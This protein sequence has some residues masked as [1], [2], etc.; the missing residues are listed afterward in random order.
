M[1]T[2][3]LVLDRR[4]FLGALATIP[5]AASIV[6]C[7]PVDD[8]DEDLLEGESSLAEG[9][10]ATSYVTLDL[11]KDC[12]AKGDGKT[13]DTSAFQEAARRIW[14]AGGGT[15]NIPAGTYIVG[16][17]KKKTNP[18]APGPFYQYEEIFTIDAREKHPTAN[19][20]IKVTKVAINGYGA[21]VRIASG[22]H[23]GGFNP[24]TGAPMDA[25]AGM[26]KEEN[27]AKIGRIFE[28]IACDG[29]SIRGLELDGNSPNLVLG[30]EW[31][32]TGRQAAA[33]GIVLE[34]CVSASV[35]DVY[36]HHHGLDGI[37]VS[38][39]GA[40]PET[41]QMHRLTR[42]ISEYNGRQAMS[43]IGGRGLRCKDCKFNHTG[44]AINKGTG[45]PL[46]SKPLA[47]VDIEPNAGT[48]EKSSEGVFISC[49]F[50]NNAGAGLLSSVGNG[51]WTTFE[52]CT[53][54]GTTSYSLWLGHPGLKFVG[55]RVYGTAM[56]VSDGRSDDD[57]KPNPALATVFEDCDF[58]DKEWK[59]GKVRRAGVL[60]EIP[61][62]KD[63]TSH[64]A[65]ATFRNCRFKANKVRGLLVKDRTSRENFIGCT[66]VHG[67][68]LGA[69]DYQSS[70][71]GSTFTSCHFKETTGVGTKNYRID[72]DN[73][74][75]RVPPAGAQPTTVD[76]PRVH[77][78]TA[79]GATGTIKPGTYTT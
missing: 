64:S 56:N 72:L 23:Y 54:W 41:T 29:V 8:E 71:E 2:K 6:G 65:G 77:W 45:Q 24:R 70:F 14:A 66:F 5:A 62:K 1:S 11:K 20:V 43:W 35:I 59:D 49:E 19:K 36:T 21:T 26:I 31:G 50:V 57:P 55:C 38:H 12:G 48:K 28:I 17:Q 15:L 37:T 63:G 51:G 44:R 33:T 42:V 3:P 46:M 47:G 10:A 76:G 30:G 32:D 27:A 61:L 60:Y 16:R 4:S 18:D 7:G 79:S 22:L 39:H 25:N 34:K 58:E 74:V 68:E 69:G 40:P 75:V 53:F 73:V 52:D 78:R 9:A 13:N 67:H